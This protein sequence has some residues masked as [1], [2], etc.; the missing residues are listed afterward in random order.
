[1]EQ[2]QKI[3]ILFVSAPFGGVE[4]LMKNLKRVVDLDHSIEPSW[5]WLGHDTRFLGLS[6][7]ASRSVNWTLKAG[8]YTHFRIREIVRSGNRIDAAFFNHIT[9]LTLLRNFRRHIPAILWADTTPRLLAQFPNH[10]QPD[11]KIKVPRKLIDYRNELTK[12]AYQEATYVLAASHIVKNSLISDY[13]IDEQRIRIVTPGI[14]LEH[15][16]RRDNVDDVRLVEGEKVKILFVGAD[17]IRKGGDL[18]LTL[19]QR[20]EFRECEFHLVTKTFEGEKPKNVHVHSDVAPNSPELVDLYSRAD[21][22]LLP[23]RA[24]FSP[25]AIGEAMAMGLPMVS[26]YVGAIP[27]MVLDGKT[28][29]LV[30]VDDW[31]A[32]ADRL[33]RL[34]K[35]RE[36]RKEFGKSA[37]QVAEENYNLQ[38]SAQLIIWSLRDAAGI[39]TGKRV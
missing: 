10:Y 21:I 14:D 13:S 12:R 25:V 38:K 26:T 9:P 8:I 37:R 35:N 22:A 7:S 24:D 2:N 33:S 36:L 11:K 16:T 39:G 3:S 19:A 28:G 29:F 1:M 18:I 4:V 34:V 30:P 15:W 23:T 17:F 20:D 32:L 6:A 31:E 27:E 5:I